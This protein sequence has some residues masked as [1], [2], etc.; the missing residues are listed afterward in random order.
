M[1]SIPSS[2]QVSSADGLGGGGGA[3]V[4]VTVTGSDESERDPS[5]YLS[6]TPL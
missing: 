5:D 1:S 4:G 6:I 2:G 3:G